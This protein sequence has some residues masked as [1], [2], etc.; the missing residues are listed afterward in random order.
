MVVCR[1]MCLPRWLVFRLPLFSHFIGFI[2]PSRGFY[3]CLY[4]SFVSV[5]CVSFFPSVSFSCYFCPLN[6]IY[7]V[8][9]HEFDAQYLNVAH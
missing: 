5:F 9:V 6:F 8:H 1:R 3:T 7:T 2:E 4:D